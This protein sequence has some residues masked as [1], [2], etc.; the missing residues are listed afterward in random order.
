M[1]LGPRPLPG[2]IDLPA[3]LLRAALFLLSGFGKVTAVAAA[4]AY[5]AAYGVSGIQ[6]WPA[7]ALEIGGGILLLLGLELRPLGL[8]LAG[9]CLLTALIVHIAFADRNQAVNLLK[10]LAMAGDFLLLAERGASTYGLDSLLSSWRIV[11]LRE[12]AP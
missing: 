4:Q 6:L 1:Q 9:W 2:W 11:P 12:P 3:R 5:M 10:N 8:V 7:A